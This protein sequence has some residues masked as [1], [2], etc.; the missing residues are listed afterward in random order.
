MDPRLA[1]LAAAHGVATEFE[2]STRQPVAVRPETVV[3]ALAL[4][5]VEAASPA[6]ISA[7]LAATTASDDRLPPTVVVRAGTTYAVPGPGLVTDEDGA[8]RE[9]DGEIP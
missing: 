3:R 7:S 9:I 4:L 6:R 2:D 1:A 8:I 5:G